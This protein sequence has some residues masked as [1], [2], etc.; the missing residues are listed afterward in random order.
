MRAGA[1]PAPR[2]RAYNGAFEAFGITVKG[3]PCEWPTT[4]YDLLQNTV[5]GGKGKMKYHFGNNGWDVATREGPVAEAGR[6][7]LVD[8][9]Q[10]AGLC[11][12]RGHLSSNTPKPLAF[13]E[14]GCSSRHAPAPPPALT[15]RHRTPPSACPRT[16]PALPTCRPALAGQED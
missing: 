14:G 15:S 6:D 9:L 16:H 13:L 3:A 10:V 8:A 7:A 5:A 1:P 2:R 12:G 11:G 4:Y